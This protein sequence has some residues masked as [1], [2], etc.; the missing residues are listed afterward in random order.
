[1]LGTSDDRT[2]SNLPKRFGTLD[3]R[4]R[5][6]LAIQQIEDGIAAGWSLQAN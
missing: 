5:R 3:G 4:I 2:K 1:M 6:R